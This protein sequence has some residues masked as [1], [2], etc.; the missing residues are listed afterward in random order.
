MELYHLIEHFCLGR[1]RLELFGTD[2]NVRQGWLTLGKALS[3]SNFDS[4]RY[5][6]WFEGDSNLL[7]YPHTKSFQGG[8][9]VGTTDEIENLRPRSPPKGR[10]QEQM[11]SIEPTEAPT[12]KE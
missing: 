4:S 6:S 11:E 2:S 7:R 3:A 10:Q 8:K 5:C 12:D 9:L 1:R